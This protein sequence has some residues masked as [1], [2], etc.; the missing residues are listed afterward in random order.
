MSSLPRLLQASL[1]DSLGYLIASATRVACA[2]NG[3]LMGVGYNQ[4]MNWLKRCIL[5]ILTQRE[6]IL[7]EGRR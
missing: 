5:S 3:G 2:R 6:K 4:E 1:S 7:R